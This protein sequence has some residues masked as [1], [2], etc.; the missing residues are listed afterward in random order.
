MAI[1]GELTYSPAFGPAIYAKAA[2][3]VVVAPI[4]GNKYVGSLVTS[5]YTYHDENDDLESGSTYQWY[6]SDTIN[7][8]G[9][10]SAIPGASGNC[11]AG[12]SINY[13]IVEA[14]LTKYL[15]LGIVPRAATDNPV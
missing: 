5:S 1:Q 13:I 2:P 6:R 4:T 3:T 8:G 12:T 10:Y 9:V 11:T 15:K 7:A 14:D